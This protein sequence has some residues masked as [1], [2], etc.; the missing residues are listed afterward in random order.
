MINLND[1]IKE[2]I[3][4]TL[5]V[6]G[7]V[8]L[9]LIFPGTLFI[10]L[11]ITDYEIAYTVFCIIMGSYF[12]DGI[13]VI[14]LLPLFGYTLQKPT[15]AEKFLLPIENYSEMQNFIDG[16]LIE[17]YQRLHTQ[18]LKDNS[19]IT[20][21]I[22]ERKLFEWDCFVIVYVSDLTDEIMNE[23]DELITE[24]LIQYNKG[25]ELTNTV[26][27]ISVICVDRITP[28]FQKLVNGNI[29]QELKIRRL[30]VG[31][32]FGGKK[33]YIAKQKDGFAIS[34][35]KRLRKHFLKIMQLS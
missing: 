4:K 7:L 35:Y 17:E 29:Q 22:K 27:M 34:Q 2:I 18:Y 24:M 6:I 26:N 13:L 16:A 5:L 20:L 9:F 21:Y 23:A 12:V 8:L 31:I 3:L 33:I 15:K 14:I 11:F 32:S 28:T 30:P 10:G 1:K 19:P 25:Q